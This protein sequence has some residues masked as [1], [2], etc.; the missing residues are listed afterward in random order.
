MNDPRYSEIHICE[1][2]PMHVVSFRAVS[3]TPEE[4]VSRHLAEWMATQ[5]LPPLRTFGFDVEVPFEQQAA[6]LR[7]Y[8]VWVV[9]PAGVVLDDDMTAR[10]FDGGLYA[11]MTIFDA[12]DDP[13]ASIPAGWEYLHHWVQ[14]N[15]QYEGAEHQM[16][17]EVVTEPA[18]AE[19]EPRRH[20]AIYYPIAA[21]AVGEPA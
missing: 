19:D 16:L 9:A 8:E 13:F 2:P 1:L 18:A 7:G 20:L 10:E 17:E 4:D 5:V 11:V 15:P 21:L 6:G 12:F 14:A 3:T